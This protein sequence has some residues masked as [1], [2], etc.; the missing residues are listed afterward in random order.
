MGITLADIFR[1]YGPAYRAQPA[2]RLRP[3]QRQAMQAIEQCRTEAL[4]GHLYTCP[5]CVQVLYRYHSCR[6]RHCPQCQG[7][8]AYT[9]LAKQQALFL[10]VPYFL[11]T[12]TLP[13]ALR[14]MARQQPRLVYD[15]L[16]RASAAA[17][18]QL[19]RDP[20]FIGGQVGLVGV[21]HTWTRDLRYHPHVHYLAPAGGLAPASPTWLPARKNFFLPVKALSRLFRTHFRQ[22]LAKTPDAPP[23]PETVWTQDWVV[24]CKSVGTG[25]T[26]LKYLAPYIFRVGLSNRRLVKLES[27]QVTFRYKEAKTG[28]TK[29]CTLPAEQFIHRFLHHVL[30]KGFVK[31]RAYGLFARSA[32]SRLVALQ[33]QLRQAPPMTPT[34]PPPAAS[35]GNAEAGRPGLARPPTDRTVRCPVCSQPMHRQRLPRPVGRCPT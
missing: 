35:E 24:H 26:A 7:A 16:F 4:G 32:R 6:N 5:Q 33:Q 8:Q 9:W 3:S 10:P 17:T 1:T 28:Q 25:E 15:C 14:S 34:P 11:L 22:L 27:D 21:L 19:A 29:F 13:A 20:R 31:V 2:N 12:F 18:Q 23:L 30:P